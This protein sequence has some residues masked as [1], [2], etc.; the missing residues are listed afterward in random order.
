[1]YLNSEE[2]PLVLPGTSVPVVT[3]LHLSSEKLVEDHPGLVGFQRVIG[4]DRSP[5]RAYVEGRRE[6]VPPQD[7][8]KLL[9]PVTI[10]P[11]GL[12]LPTDVGFRH[13]DAPGILR[14]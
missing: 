4:G 2:T 14:S 7:G 6:P 10:H 9:Y 11:A 5:T 3:S 13:H 12:T 1:M 8:R